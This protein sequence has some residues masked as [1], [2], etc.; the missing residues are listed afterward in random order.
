MRI[1]YLGYLII[2]YMLIGC[3]NDQSNQAKKTEQIIAENPVKPDSPHSENEEEAEVITAPAQPLPDDTGRVLTLIPKFSLISDQRVIQNTRYQFSPELLQGE[4]VLWLK[5]FGPDDIQVDPRNGTISWDIPQD[6]PN[7]SFHLGIS[8]HNSAG[9]FSDTWILTVG[10]GNLVYIGPN[11]EHKTLKN[12]LNA[13]NSGD[14]LVMRDGIWDSSDIDN[15]IPGSPRKGQ[16]LP[17][18]TERA[19]TT[20]MAENPG[21]AILDGQHQQKIISQ[22]GSWVHPDWSNSVGSWQ[23]SINYTAIK[24]LVLINSANEGLRIDY[25][26]HIKLINL[27][28]GPSAKGKDSYANVYIHKSKKILIEGMYVWGHGRYKIQIKSSTETVVRRSIVRIDDYD[29]DEPLGAFMPYCAADVSFQNNI[30]IDTDHSEYWLNFYE[31]AN[32]F[33]EAATNCLDYPYGIKFQRGLVLNS[34]MPAMASAA[35][36]TAAETLFEDIVAWDIRPDRHNAGKGSGVPIIQGVGN[37]NTNRATL[38]NIRLQNSDNANYYFYSRSQDSTVQNSILYQ[39]GFNGSENEYNGDLVRHTS[40]DFYLDN[41]NLVDFKGA[42]SDGS[43][44]PSESNSLNINPEF[45]YITTLPRNSSLR[46]LANDGGRIGAEIM[47]M[48]GKSGSFHGEPG[49]DQ[50]THIPMWPFPNEQLAHQHMSQYE[51]LA[52]DRNGNSAGIQGDRGFASSGQTLS[53]YIWSYLG[54][55]PPPLNVSSFIQ[56]ND[57]ILRWQ[58]F[59]T[60]TQEN[61]KEYN[62]YLIN[63]PTSKELITTIAANVSHSYTFINK[64]NEAAQYAITA[65][66]LDGN[67]SDYAFPTN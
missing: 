63:S 43:G 57:K 38:G 12:G 47:T 24:G 5:S 29:G 64:D 44:T 66:R 16:K 51:L 21:Q 9:E 62:I 2:T 58:A 56:G 60:S 8:A 49:Y 45:R 65:V 10:D 25:G 1:Q 3:Y 61:I 33:G 37:T 18:G 32:A 19:Y 7:E 17:S 36:G 31:L 22:Y 34:H 48:L 20:L 54:E 46:N 15:T 11:E 41:N 55:T 67:E 59:P 30:L 6:L 50:E 42:L 13:I 23:G 53:N 27:G 40:A 35:K 52:V 26:H 28:I 14:T 4:D 39:F